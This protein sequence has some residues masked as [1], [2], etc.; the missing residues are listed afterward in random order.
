M[1]ESVISHNLLE[2]QARIAQTAER[3]GRNQEDIRMVAISKGQSVEKIRAGY[4]AGIRDFGENRV[5]EATPKLDALNDLEDIKWHMVGHVQSRKARLI[6]GAF[7]VVH[8]LDRMKLAQRLNRFAGENNVRLPVL[9]ECNVSGESTKYGWDLQ[10][11]MTWQAI[12]PE[13]SQLISMDNLEILGLMTMA[14]WATDE[15]VI[16][17]C[18]SKLRD[19]RK[20]LAA[21]LPGEWME[22][23]M[24]MT[25]DFEL[26]IEEGATILRIGRAIFG[27]R[28]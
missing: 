16:R 23:S 25:D 17:T 8:S 2:V 20:F 11:E 6:P 3:A 19:L 14:P 9:L 10:D 15:R 4:E 24:G 12:L 27:D 13:F 1:L 7:D 22:L 26:A 18:F 28:E 21:H 5:H